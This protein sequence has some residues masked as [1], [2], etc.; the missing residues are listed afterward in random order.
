M[1]ERPCGVELLSMNQE[2]ELVLF[3]AREGGGHVQLSVALDPSCIHS[4]ASHHFVEG[5]GSL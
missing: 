2:G 4:F 3:S 1:G 5:F